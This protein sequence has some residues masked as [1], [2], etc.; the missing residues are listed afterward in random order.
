MS[1]TPYSYG[2]YKVTVASDGAIKVKSGDMLS[3]YS[4]A[5]YHDF[6]QM[7]TRFGRK[8]SGGAVKTF[9]DLPADINKITA[10]ETLY[11]IKT[12][13]G[14]GG[15]GGG[16]REQYTPAQLKAFALIDQFD[17]RTGPTTFKQFLR[18]QVANE[19]RAR[20][21]DPHQIG[22]DGAGV[23]GPT[24]LLF[25][26][27]QDDPVGYVQLV[28][29]LYEYGR[30]TAAKLTVN[31]TRQFVAYV[32]S[33]NVRHAADWIPEGSMRNANDWFNLYPKLGES[34][35]PSFPWTIAEWFKEAGYSQSEWGGL[36]MPGME[37]RVQWMTKLG[38]MISQGWRV[39]LLINH[40]LEQ[41]SPA[42]Y[43]R[44]YPDHYVG[45]IQAP[46]FTPAGDPTNLGDDL[47]SLTIFS[48]RREYDVGTK[49][50]GTPRPQPLTV[51][52]VMRYVFSYSAGR[53]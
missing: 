39:V 41:M 40:G 5:I 53:Y 24:A 44:L 1:S 14:N 35:G 33:A 25:N 26:L 38:Y 13:A 20:V 3:H 17:A 46:V 22:Q 47:M 49:S 29:D 15:G 2:G 37:T 34:F 28:T 9:A 31:P 16:K 52:E 23:C 10:G 42:F 8:V 51:R 30:G 27:A 48:H 12:H 36:D 19:L 11:D 18:P 6:K 32:P 4:M 43:S 7:D 45:M 50:Y 21:K